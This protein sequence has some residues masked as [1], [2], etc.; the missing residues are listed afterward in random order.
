MPEPA[1]TLLVGSG[2]VALIARRRRMWASCS[3]IP[4]MAA[5]RAS[6]RTGW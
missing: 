5:A 4:P 2:V 6:C 3:A 1:T